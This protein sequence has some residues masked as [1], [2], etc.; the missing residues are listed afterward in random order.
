MYGNPK[1]SCQTPGV[2]RKK[3][4]VV[5]NCPTAIVLPTAEAFA[6]SGR[7]AISVAIL[8]SA[9]LNMFDTPW[10]LKSECN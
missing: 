7:S 4:S 1:S 6:E 3:L 8:T 10:V 2:V 5:M 9:I